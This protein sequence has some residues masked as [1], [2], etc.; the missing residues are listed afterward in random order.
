MSTPA[1]NGQPSSYA[2]TCF[3]GALRE[4]DC[5]SLAARSYYAEFAPMGFTEF[6][7]GE[8]GSHKSFRQQRPGGHH[9][10]CCRRLRDRDFAAP[11]LSTPAFH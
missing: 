6:G 1:E 9:G 10:T 3:I 5:N 7:G 8:H 4:L 2:C 11:H